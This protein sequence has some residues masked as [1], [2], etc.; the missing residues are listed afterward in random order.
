MPTTGWA[1]WLPLVRPHLPPHLVGPSSWRFLERSTPFLPAEG[2]GVFELHLRSDRAA[3]DFSIGLTDPAQA[4]DLLERQPGLDGPI[5]FPWSREAPETRGVSALW[6]EFDQGRFPETPTAPLELPPPVVCAKLAGRQDPAWLTDVLLPVLEP[7]GL[8]PAQRDTVRRCLEALPTEARCLYVFHL[9]ARGTRAL[10]LEISGLSAEGMSRFLERMVSP[11]AARQIEPAARL[12]SGGERFHLSID[13]DREISPRIGIEHSF[14]RQP[15]REPGWATT[16][17][18]LEA[19][20]LC[21]AEQRRAVL[22]WCGVDTFWKSPEVWPPGV[23]GGQAIRCLSHLKL[24]T[25]PDRAPEAKAYLLFRHLRRRRDSRDS[26]RPT[27]R[28]RGS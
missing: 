18:R 21:N 20:G 27:A 16:L 17:R 28:S 5:L 6:L 22:A 8:D 23:I 24:V 14:L 4:R 25:W 9:G 7:R 1:V 26:E 19:A 11:R 10:R 12:F 13:L 3:V 2:T 15:R